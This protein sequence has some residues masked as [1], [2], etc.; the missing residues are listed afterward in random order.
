[1]ETI[2]IT[3][4]AMKSLTAH[5]AKGY[6]SSYKK[7]VGGFL[8]GQINGRGYYI[9]E[10]IS[11]N[12]RNAGRT[13]W[14]P[15]GSNM[16][17]K[18]AILEQKTGYKLMGAYHSHP[19]TAGHASTRQSEEDKESHISSDYLLDIIIRVTPSLMKSPAA[20][21]TVQYCETGYYYDICGHIK[22]HDNKIRRIKVEEA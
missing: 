5:A 11:Y 18:G 19:E 21:L 8:L 7:E 2:K 3:A 6:E 16:K 15:N 4:K 10:A 9:R 20:C 17:R 12:T 22:G 13:Y 1:M 14:S